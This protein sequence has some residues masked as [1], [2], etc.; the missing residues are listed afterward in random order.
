LV[1]VGLLAMIYAT[2]TRLVLQNLLNFSFV[3]DARER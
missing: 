1:F 3:T 2:L